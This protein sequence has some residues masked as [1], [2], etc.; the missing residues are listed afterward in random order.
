MR[1]SLKKSPTETP[2]KILTKKFT[3]AKLQP[4]ASKV[5]SSIKTLSCVRVSIF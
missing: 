4:L 2:K 3:T 1:P 5:L